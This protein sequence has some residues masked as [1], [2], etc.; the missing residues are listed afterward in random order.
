MLHN[1]IP[2][3]IHQTA[4]NDMKKWHP[5]WK[6]CQKT[7]MEKFDFK[8]ILWND[9]D[10]DKLIQVSYP[11][12]YGV[13]QD[14]GKNVILKVDFARLAM[15]HKYGGIYA[16]MDFFC[17]KNFYKEL[18]NNINLVGSPSHNEIVQNSLMASPPGDARWLNV[19]DKCRERYYRYISEGREG[20]ISGKDVLY[21]SG[22]ILLS[23]SLKLDEVNIL[24]Q[25]MYNPHCNRFDNKNIYTK[26][27]GTGKW[28]PTSGNRDFRLRQP[29]DSVLLNFYKKQSKETIS[30]G[31]V[32]ISVG[33]SSARC[34]KLTLPNIF[35]TSC[36][37]QLIDHKYND[38]FKIEADGKILEITRTDK[39]QGWGHDHKILIIGKEVGKKIMSYAHID[40]FNVDVLLTYELRDT[41]K[42]RVGKRGD[43]GYCIIPHKKYDALISGGISYDT[44][45]EE[46]L[47]QLYPSLNGYCYDGSVN[48][49]PVYNDRLVFHKL[50]ISNK[51]T[52]NT[53]NLHDVI[54]RYDDI[55]MKM[56]IEGSEF[57]FLDS[58]TSDHM[59]RI[60]Q[61]VI[62]IH[63]PDTLEKW[64]VLRKL[65]QSHYLVHV[66]GN[67]FQKLVPLAELEKSIVKVRVEPSDSYSKTI[68]LSCPIQP[69]TYLIID[70]EEL[71]D[72][73]HHKINEDGKSITITSKNL[74]GWVKEFNLMLYDMKIKLN[75]SKIRVPLVF[76]CTYVRK[77][78]VN[79]LPRKNKHEL[80]SIIDYPNDKS[81]E[82]IDL[83]YYPFVD[84]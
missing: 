55:F 68:R 39:K 21:I 81:R 48:D 36:K 65:Q 54:E 18:D 69:S 47:L 62:E 43:G 66:H 27:Y 82:D 38:T 64:N 28:G 77:S 6:I 59:Q 26:H 72:K 70:D 9:E 45:F 33:S 57:D 35:P 19:M 11:T 29:L 56:D 15:L 73:F 71:R 60:K 24:E 12:Y 31:S 78:D 2:K 84:L 83:N 30:D 3:I 76:E 25:K 22:P 52:E 53:T 75:N 50:Y 1:G 74:K 5:F 51:N 16:D 46:H 44:S 49:L 40:N 7:W 8:Y 13:Y 10:L 20:L 63:F 34:K 37:Y 79:Y 58:L 32:Y 42:I 14:F 23:D 17:C 67:N 41:P 4:P 61:L 80:P